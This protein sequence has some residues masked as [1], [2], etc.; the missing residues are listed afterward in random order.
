MRH[1]FARPFTPLAILALAADREGGGCGGA[2]PATS[3]APT[4]APTTTVGASAAPVASAAVGG[5]RVGTA[6]PPPV[7][8]ATERVA[9]LAV[10]DV[11]LR[12]L[13]ERAAGRPAPVELRPEVVEDLGRLIDGTAGVGRRCLVEFTLT[14]TPNWRFETVFF[15]PLLNLDGSPA[16]A[17]RDEGARLTTVGLEGYRAAVTVGAPPPSGATPAA[18]PP[19]SP[20]TPATTGATAQLPGDGRRALRGEALIVLVEWRD[21]AW[22]ATAVDSVGTPLP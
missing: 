16:G 2:A 8:D 1:P 5:P 22:V 7:D 9:Q 14:A 21:G 6:T 17:A 19:G 15:A 20:C 11:A 4:V 3:P 13:S 12:A 18:L 10:A